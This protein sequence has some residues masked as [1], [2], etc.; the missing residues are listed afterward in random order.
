MKQQ[1]KKLTLR[2]TV[3][4]LLCLAFLIGIILNPTLL[5]ANKTKVGNYI[6]YHNAPLDENFILRLGNAWNL[7][8][9]T[10]V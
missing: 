8:N 3:T 6:I 2:L 5:Y 9:L 4:G 1:I 10:F 7:P